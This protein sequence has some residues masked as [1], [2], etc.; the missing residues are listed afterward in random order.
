[1]KPVSTGWS[2]SPHP[3]PRIAAETRLG[4]EQAD[5]ME[6]RQQ[7]GGRKP[8]DS[9]ADDGNALGAGFDAQIQ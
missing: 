8:R 7:I 9:A 1:M 4:F 6:R 2:P 5:G 3:P